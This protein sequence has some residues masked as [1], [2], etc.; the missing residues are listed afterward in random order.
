MADIE[1]ITPAATAELLESGADFTLLDV[2][3]PWEAEIAALP[4]SVLIP[5]GEISDR[6]GELDA[7]K[8]VIA[9]C[10]GGVRSMHAAK[11][12]QEAGL[13]VRSMAGGIDGWSRTVDTDVP[14]Y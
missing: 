8:P 13:Q 7:S 5:L 12:L 6:L 14:R 11:K 9:Y 2:R 3:E 1:E 10:H 4:G